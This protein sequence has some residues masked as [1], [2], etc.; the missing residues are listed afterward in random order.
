MLAKDWVCWRCACEE[1]VGAVAA[2]KRVSDFLA[3]RAMEERLD[4]V[5]RDASVAGVCTIVP[6][7]VDGVDDE[8][9][10]GSELEGAVLNLRRQCRHARCPQ[11]LMSKVSAAC[12]R[13]R[14]SVL[15]VTSN[16]DTEW[17]GLEKVGQPR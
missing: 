15:M 16:R 1:G 5:V 8:S 3:G 12:C 4:R 2:C 11:K 14:I 17:L 13:R 9:V 6:D 10:E 7:M